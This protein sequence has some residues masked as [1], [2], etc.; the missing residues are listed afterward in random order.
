ML[1]MSEGEGEGR[2]GQGRLGIAHHLER[3]AA[4][5]G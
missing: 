3:R 1:K 2:A 5:G 4:F